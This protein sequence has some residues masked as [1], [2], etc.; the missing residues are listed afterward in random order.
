[1]VGVTQL[2]RKV[3]YEKGLLAET[4]VLTRM[5]QGKR[6]EKCFGRRLGVGVCVVGE[7]EREGGKASGL[8]GQGGCGRGRRETA[9]ARRD[10]GRGKALK[11]VGR[12]DPQGRMPDWTLDRGGK[13]SKL[14]PWGPG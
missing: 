12:R 3:S 8:G 6:W 10:G 1:M 11:G 9:G 13:S 4:S 5:A 7:R 2:G 14:T